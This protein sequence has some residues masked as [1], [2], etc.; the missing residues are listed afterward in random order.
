MSAEIDKLRGQ[1]KNA[2]KYE[3]NCLKEFYTAEYILKNAR[4]LTQCARNRLVKA[5]QEN[6]VNP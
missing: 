4:T 3:E 1:L 2:E 6:E 5:L